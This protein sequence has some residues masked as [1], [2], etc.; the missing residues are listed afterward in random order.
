MIIKS[1]APVIFEFLKEI[2]AQ[3]FS[4]CLVGGVP[5]DYF[6]TGTMGNDF[7]FEIRPSEVLDDPEKSWPL[8]YKKLHNYLSQKK[9][10][11]TELPYLI[12]RVYFEGFFFE[13]SSPRTERN[14]P[15]NFSH[16]HFTADLNPSL[17]YKQSFKR[18]DFTI[19][20]IG[21]ELHFNTV[22]EK[23]VDPYNGLEDLKNG[24]L[25]NI[26]EDFFF[27][28]VRFLRL[29]RFHIKF[30]KFSIHEKIL[31][32]LHQFVLTELSIHHFKEELFKSRPGAFLNT[33]SELVISRKLIIPDAFVFWTR[34]LFP[35]NIATR[36]ELLAFVYLKND[37]DAEK[38]VS[39][40]SMPEK[41]LK[42]LKSFH[43]SVLELKE[44][45]KED[46]I[47][48]ISLP[49]EVSLKSPILKELKNLEEKK[50]WRSVFYLFLDFKLP[51]D[52][53]EWENVIVDQ[54]EINKI[55]PSSRSYYQF[56]KALLLKYSDG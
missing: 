25:K 37:K 56:Y 27:D 36:E 1:L 29:I 13:F 48:L 54:E 5:R 11:F 18:R 12:T 32:Q 4:L 26:S 51:L 50:E 28:S 2:E 8:F 55:S 38:I 40:F 34:Y 47:H 46:M 52:W 21:V 10:A 33:F 22:S 53:N 17:S 19:N 43:R 23:T 45:G 42:D 49:I 14:L 24:V 16:H 9:L 35:E 44:L 7:D 31:S 30:E 3:G 15:D 41:K 6:Y 20:G 39:F